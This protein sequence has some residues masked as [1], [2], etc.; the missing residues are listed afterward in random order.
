MQSWHKR[1]ALGTLTLTALAV[2]GFASP[3]FA[4][5]VPSTTTAQTSP[6]TAVTGQSVDLSAKVTCAQDPSGGLGMSFFDGTNLLATV[7]VGAGGTATYST[8][9]SSTGVH[10]ITAAYNGNDNC[11]ASNDTTTA[12]VTAPLP[13]PPPPPGPVIVIDPNPVA[14][15]HT[16]RV[17]DG[18]DHHL[19]CKPGTKHATVW[20]D[21]FKDGEIEL[22]R[23]DRDDGEDHDA[24]VGYGWAVQRPGWYNVKLTCDGDS[25]PSGFGKLHV[26]PRGAD[27]GD[28]ASILAGGA[29]GTQSALGFGLLGS[30]A[31]VGAFAL[32]RKL[33]AN[34]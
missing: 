22:T 28:G 5:A 2:A 27:T 9:F 20:S 6:S 30:A 10:T 13:P 23:H 19:I 26:V 1:R 8:S 12:Q 11:D 17:S 21:G 15:G 16:L 4:A 33:K 34:R 25:Q 14:A 3:A 31:G 7:P 24:L 32:R 29:S 18:Y